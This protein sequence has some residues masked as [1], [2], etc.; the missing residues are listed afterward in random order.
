MKYTVVIER[1]EIMKTIR[2]HAMMGNGV[3]NEYVLDENSENVT[4]EDILGTLGVP[5]ESFKNVTWNKTI[6][7]AL[8]SAGRKSV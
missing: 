6:T 5:L 4:D 3:F 8:P 7:R 1:N 2:V